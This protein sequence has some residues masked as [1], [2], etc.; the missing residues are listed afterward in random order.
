MKTSIAILSALVL[1]VGMTHAEEG[2]GEKHKKPNPRERFDKADSDGS[3]SISLSEFQA[4]PRAKEK[5]EKAAEIFKK[6]DADGSDDISP[7]EMINFAKEHKKHHG[8]K[9]SDKKRPEKEGSVL[10]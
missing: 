5:P 2:G 7:E 8:E 4:T 9:P 3:G 6:I 1:S 10:E